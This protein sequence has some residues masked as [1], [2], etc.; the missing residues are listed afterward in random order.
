MSCPGTSWRMR[1]GYRACGYCGSMHPDDLFTAIDA[2][3]MITGTDKNYKIYV[4]APSVDPAALKVVSADS[5]E[6]MPTWGSGWQR[7]TDENRALMTSQGWGTGHSPYKWIMVQP[8]GPKTHCKFYYEHF[9]DAHQQRFLDLYNARKM[10][11][12]PNFG[13]YVLPFFASRRKPQEGQGQ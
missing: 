8:Q 4:D 9:D 11:L 12:E 13:L 2:G 3:A 5:G 10:N 6:E 7:V 1:D